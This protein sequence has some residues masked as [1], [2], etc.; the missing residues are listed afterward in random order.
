M[1]DGTERNPPN[2]TYTC[3]VRMEHRGG[4][5]KLK[6][7]H[8]ERGIGREKKKERKTQTKEEEQ[9]ERKRTVSITKENDRYANSR[10][11]IYVKVNLFMIQKLT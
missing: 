1:L 6:E 4:V 7:E 2:P 5:Y 3:A 11:S 10:I 9:K 8:V